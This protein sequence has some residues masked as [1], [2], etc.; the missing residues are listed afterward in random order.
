MTIFIK[1]YHAQLNMVFKKYH[2]HICVKKIIIQTFLYIFHPKIII[3]S[4]ST[5]HIFL[6]TF[7]QTLNILQFTNYSYVHR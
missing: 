2:Y 3:F 4:I 1:H 6:D 5:D 7:I